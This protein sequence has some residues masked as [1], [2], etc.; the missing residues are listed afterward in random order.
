MCYVSTSREQRNIAERCATQCQVHHLNLVHLVHL[1]H[2]DH[3]FHLVHLVHL[4]Q[5]KNI[6]PGKRSFQYLVFSGDAASHDV[7]G[8]KD[9]QEEAA[10]Q[11]DHQEEAAISSQ[12]GT[13][14]NFSN[15]GCEI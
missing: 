6:C 4:V 2:L 10:V 11:K 5:C 13:D 7:G 15:D 9:Y 1:D 3:L 8:Q 14:Y 12:I